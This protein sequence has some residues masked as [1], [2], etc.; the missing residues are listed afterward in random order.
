MNTALSI[1]NTHP[2]E[3]QAYPGTLG[4]RF[5]DVGAGAPVRDGLSVSATAESGAVA[6][7]VANRSGVWQFPALPGVNTVDVLRAL[8]AGESLASL[9]RSF[10]V[11]VE[12]RAG[13]FHRTS[14]GV[15]APVIGGLFEWSH[16]GI[17]PEGSPPRPTA[18]PLFSTASRPAPPGLLTVR[19]DLWDIDRSAPAAW[20]LLEIDAPGA[21]GKER[22]IG[23]AG[24]NGSV[25]VFLPVPFIPQDGSRIPASAR[26]FGLDVRVSYAPSLAVSSA[27]GAAAPGIPSL[28]TVL[29]QRDV[30]AAEPLSRTYPDVVLAAAT[31]RA[32]EPLLLATDPAGLEPR[33][34][35]RLLLRS[36]A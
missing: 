33:L 13:R 25:Q 34:T 24:E 10:V 1:D 36:M 17:E 27:S 31:L 8:E 35:S 28:T 19:A 29:S 7:A 9:Q 12:D 15:S 26:T 14:F 21:S 16:G 11:N 4:L 5:W 2:V 22:F 32:V 6:L 30:A 23:L 20:G 3:H 18:V